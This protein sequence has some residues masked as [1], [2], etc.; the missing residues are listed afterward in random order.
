MS[1]ANLLDVHQPQDLLRGL[2]N[3]INEYDQNKDEGDKSKIRPTKRLFR[4]KTAKRA[5][6]SSFTEY[7]GPFSDN[8]PD[9]S[10]LIIPHIA[11]PLDYHQTLISL[12]DVISEVYNKISKMLGPSPIAQPFQHM[13]GPLGLLSPHPGVSYIFSADAHNHLSQEHT[14]EKG[15]LWSIANPGGN[16]IMPSGPAGAYQNAWSAS[17]GEMVLKF[18][19]KVKKIT[20]SVLKELDVFAR[21]GIKE[22]LASLDPLLGS[23]GAGGKPINEEG[24]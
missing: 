19:S 23:I 11:F 16:S 24:L 14:P 10:Y 22:E 18:D 21:N 20:S 15:S 9:T 13:M 12:L 7:A 1:L 6:A 2:I 5:G 17:L 3:V 8:S 4:P